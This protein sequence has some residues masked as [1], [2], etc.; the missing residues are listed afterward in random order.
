[1]TELKIQEPFALLSQSTSDP[2][3][4]WSDPTSVMAIEADGERRAHSYAMFTHFRSVYERR[5]E[6]SNGYTIAASVLT[7]IKMVHRLLFT[8]LLFLS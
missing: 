4:E 2:N 1:M 7:L 8:L 5:A 6:C 3:I